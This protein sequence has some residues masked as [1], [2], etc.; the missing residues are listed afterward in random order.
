SELA[1]E[2]GPQRASRASS[3]L[4]VARMESR[5]KVSTHPGFHP[6]YMKALL[7]IQLP[8]NFQAT[9]SQSPRQEAE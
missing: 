5:E 3:L 1:R 4:L 9:R 2:L 7:S 6:G 8:R